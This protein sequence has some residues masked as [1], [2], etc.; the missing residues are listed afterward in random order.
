VTERFVGRVAGLWRGSFNARPSETRQY[1]RLRSIF[2]ALSVVGGTAE[3]VLYRDAQREAVRDRLLG[4]DGVWRG[5]T[6][7][8]RARAA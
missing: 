4:F 7:S 5:W 6:R 1:E 3:P 8:A 2:D